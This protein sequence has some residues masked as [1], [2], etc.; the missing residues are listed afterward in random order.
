MKSFLTDFSV[1][2]K[3]LTWNYT[4]I[5]DSSTLGKIVSMNMNSGGVCYVTTQKDNEYTTYRVSYEHHQ[6]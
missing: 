3:E 2:E 6:D 4:P 1:V 5:T